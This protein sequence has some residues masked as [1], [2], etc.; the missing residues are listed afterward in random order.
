MKEKF[1]KIRNSIKK[2]LLS[3]ARIKG[4]KGTIEVEKNIFIW[5][6]FSI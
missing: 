3:C 1:E 5:F 2:F 4:V 6:Y